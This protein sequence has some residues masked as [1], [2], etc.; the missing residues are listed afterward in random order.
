MKPLEHEYKVMGLAPYAKE[1]DITSFQ[2]KTGIG[3]ILNT[4]F[5][6]HGEPIVCYPADAIRTF[7][8]SGLGTLVL[9]NIIVKR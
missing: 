5:N 2:R 8:N 1:V 4:S 3:A 6:L 9:E 7:W